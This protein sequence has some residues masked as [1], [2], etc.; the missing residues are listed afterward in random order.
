MTYEAFFVLTLLIKVEHVLEHST[1]V[2][3]NFSDV[4]PFM[5][6]TMAWDTN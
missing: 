1:S 5:N 4:E 2:L 3:I 6:P